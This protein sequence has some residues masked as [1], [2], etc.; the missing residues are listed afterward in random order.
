MITGKKQKGKYIEKK[1]K[2]GLWLLNKVIQASLYAENTER[3][4]SFMRHIDT[5]EILRLLRENVSGYLPNTNSPHNPIVFYNDLFTLLGIKDG[6]KIFELKHKNDYYNIFPKYK[7]GVQNKNLKNVKDAEL[8]IITRRDDPDESDIDSKKEPPEKSFNY[9]GKEYV[10]DSAVLRDKE[11]GH[12]TSYVTIGGNEFAF[13]GAAFRKLRSFNWKN[14]LI[15]G[16]N[17]NWNFGSPLETNNPSIKKEGFGLG[18]T[19]NFKHGYQLLF[20]YK[21]TKGL[22]I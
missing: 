5:N 13:E 7:S 15:N 10:L 21:D 9:G 4:S 12:F 18:E 16:K 1:Y 6:V 17:S 8:I 2:M 20:Y 22:I 11:K 14:K 3:T 19:F